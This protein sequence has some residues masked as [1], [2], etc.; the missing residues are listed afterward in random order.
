MDPVYEA[1]RR[2]LVKEWQLEAADESRPIE[3]R[4]QAH[5]LALLIELESGLP[6]MEDAD[7]SAFATTE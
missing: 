3:D 4:V 6:I 5:A 7:V 1:M 2:V